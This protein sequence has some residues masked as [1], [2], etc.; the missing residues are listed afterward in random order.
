TL[1]GAA[2]CCYRR[3]SPPSSTI[4]YFYK[5]NRLR[6]LNNQY[7][8]CFYC[9]KRFPLYVEK[10]LINP[11]DCTNNDRREIARTHLTRPA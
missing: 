6:F 3:P 10:A 9:N 11:Y 2:P 7:H 1:R 8:F 5:A 4:Y